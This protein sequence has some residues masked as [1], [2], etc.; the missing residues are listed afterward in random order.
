MRKIIYLFTIALLAVSCGNKAK[1]V[2]YTV[3]SQKGDCMGVAPQKCLLVKKGDAAEWEFFYG[4][5]EGFNHEDG[6][7]YVLEVKEDINEDAPADM[8]LIKYTLVKEISKTA[9]TSENLPAPLKRDIQWV[10]KVLEIE[11]TDVGK[12]AA[13]GKFPVT[14][15]KVEVTSTSSDKLK[16]GEIIH[17]ELVPEPLVKPE[18]GR[19]YAFRAKDMHPAHAKGVYMLETNLQ[20]LI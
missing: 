20:D 3:A 2:K 1:T 4:S 9:K 15:L 11:Y 6:Y 18:E 5:I 17:C 19:E 8:S 14:V 12:G 16:D 10:G 7:E 13:E